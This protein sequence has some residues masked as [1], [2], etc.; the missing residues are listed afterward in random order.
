MEK[1][2][3]RN[4]DVTVPAADLDESYPGCEENSPRREA[5]AEYGSLIQQQRNH[6]N[7]G[8]GPPAIQNFRMSSGYGGGVGCGLPGSPTLLPSHPHPASP[9]IR[10]LDMSPSAN[11]SYGPAGPRSPQHPAS[12]ARPLPPGGEAEPGGGPSSPPRHS[13]PRHAPLHL[14]LPPHLVPHSSGFPGTL[15]VLTSS[16]APH[17]PDPFSALQD[18][19]L[20]HP[21]ISQAVTATWITTSNSL[22]G[23]PVITIGVK[24]WRNRCL[25][26]FR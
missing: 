1:S 4:L 16:P 24:T 18:L 7:L 5:E 26:V 21:S 9:V 13:P 6:I 19:R 25:C 23:F 8:I 12:P 20:S 15:P 3:P 2:L 10:M 14:P 11:G 22:L 17:P